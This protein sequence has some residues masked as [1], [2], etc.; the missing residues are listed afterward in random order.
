M[1]VATLQ[2]ELVGSIE[3]HERLGIERWE[4]TYRDLLGLVEHPSRW[5]FVIHGSTVGYRTRCL[6]FLCEFDHLRKA[7]RFALCGRGD[8]L[9]KA[10]ATYRVVPLKCGSRLCPRCAR[11]RGRKVV[12]KVF[13]H[14]R[15]DGHGDL[16]HVVLTQPINPGEALDETRKR[17]AAKW[18]KTRERLT[19]HITS[20]V[21]TEH[22]KWSVNAKGWHCHYHVFAECSSGE[23][24]A[25][26]WLL[27]AKEVEFRH[28]TD[29][30]V[31]H[32]AGPGEQILDLDPAQGEFWQESQSEIAKAVQ[33]VV[34]DVAEGPNPHALDQVPQQAFEEYAVV[35]SNCKLHR[36]LG[37]WRRKPA[38]AACPT[39]EATADA[40]DSGSV[41]AS[42]EEY[43][44]GT[45]D[46]VLSG[47]DLA[48]HHSFL[49]FL[50]DQAGGNR[51]EFGKRL[52]AVV[53]M[54]RYY[55]EKGGGN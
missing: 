29:P 30:Y 7:E 23:R 47:A 26:V 39:E 49:L 40:S 16:W 14:L 38:P 53:T 4:D 51:S 41:P 17:L 10:G 45:V 32:V 46:A 27:A 36:C 48:E 42:S 31:R 15:A 33:Y 9:Y 18:K 55:Q 1:S 2:T 43:C 34:R 25:D 11:Y 21:V 19:G 13:D 44:V 20:G 22:I 50:L 3:D 12:R 5:Q 28:H 52:R 35:M 37:K 8:N 6:K 24:I 54:V